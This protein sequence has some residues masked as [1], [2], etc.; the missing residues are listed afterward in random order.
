MLT[1]LRIRDFAIID[2][3][4]L[5]CGPGFVV[6]T[7][8][9]GAGKSILIDAVEVL[10]GGRAEAT[11]IRSEAPVALVEG[12]FRLVPGGGDEARRLLEAEGL[13]ED[14]ETLLLSREIRREGRTVGRVNGRAVSVSLLRLLGESL[15]DVHGQSEHLSLLR[16]RE[17]LRLLDRYAQ[18]E[19]L[20]GEFG[21]G[22]S[23]LESAR[24]E[25]K[26]LREAERD[27]SRRS[28]L[29]AFQVNEIEAASLRPGEEAELLEERVR[30][31][32]A[33]QLASLAE[34]AV[35][36]LDEAV[37][38]RSSASDR[39]GEAAEAVAALARIDGTLSG[40]EAEAQA[41]LEQAGDLARRLRLYR[42][43]IESSPTRLD[44]VEERIGLIRSLQR[45]YGESIEAV[46]AKAAAARE[47]LET[48]THAGERIAAL[49][50][51]EARQ[52]QSLGETGARL[53]QRRRDA[54]KSLAKAIETELGDLR[55]GGARF[56]VDLAWEDDPAGAPVGDRRVSFGPDGLDRVEFLVAPNPG[57]GLKPLVKIAS[58]GETSRMMLG[59]KGVL[60]R[61]D[62]TPTLIF[63]EID[64]GIGGRVGAIVGRKL[65]GLARGHQVLCVTHLPQLAAF[66]DQHFK[67]EKRVVRGRTTTAV[68]AVEGEGR[69]AE[70]AQML[71][72]ES[73]ASQRSAAE[74]LEQADNS[75]E[76]AGTRAN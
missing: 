2:E 22:Y 41:L 10:L 66:G 5:D 75:K 16:V 18:V 44:E 1:E 11:M 28:E 45:K 31:A 8:E 69:I 60:A 63:D 67:V 40:S 72:A 68:R 3:L 38:D 46:L 32:N 13:L 58:G 12:S 43:G 71:G 4:S 9:T 73:E 6:F 70:L 62:Q 47:E 51:E 42:E 14:G 76:A 36:A 52:L 56:S 48:I 17:H 57:E 7:G 53:S 50:Q 15:V 74:L 30:L 64:Q 39:L 25:L 34:K 27:A 54:G 29:L 61:A 65:W 19:D 59:L 35:A 49:E 55:M 21:A 37:E 33:E 23:R 26:Q 24:R 20:R